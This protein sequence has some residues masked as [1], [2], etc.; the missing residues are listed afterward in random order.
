MAA[1]ADSDA[2]S[3]E[4]QLAEQVAYYRALAPDYE[5]G[6]L[7]DDGAAELETALEEFAPGGGVLELACGPG[8]WTVQLARHAASLTAVDASPEMLARAR[9]RVGG[10]RTRFIC[11]DV[12]E[13]RADRR[14]D[15]VVFGFWLSHVPLERFDRFWS[16]VGECLK[17]DGRVFFVDDAHITDDERIAGEPGSRVKRLLKD[18]SAHRIFKVAHTPEQLEQRLA[19]LGWQIRV[20]ATSGPFYWGEGT[21]ASV[22]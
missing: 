5:H 6:A 21:A 18:G 14:Y 11:S 20:S 4:P 15:A 9:R 10:E 13:W 2:V 1:S 7:S 17:P 19:G 22:A 12:F 3:L 8:T 16:L